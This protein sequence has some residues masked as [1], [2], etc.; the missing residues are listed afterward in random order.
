[1][2]ESRPGARALIVPANALLAPAPTPA[3]AGLNPPG[4]GAAATGSSVCPQKSQN[5]AA[6]RTGLLHFGQFTLISRASD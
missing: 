1:M 4:A 6:S 5:R 3:A 2:R